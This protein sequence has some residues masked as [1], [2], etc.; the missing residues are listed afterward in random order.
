MGHRRQRSRPRPYPGGVPHPHQA[1]LVGRGHPAIRATHAKTFELT[2]EPAISARATCVLAVGTVLD[3]NLAPLR[4]RV[5][6][7]LATPGLPA[8]TGE[9]TL[10]PRRALTDRAVIRRSRTLDADTLAVDSTLTADDLPEAFAAA[11]TDPGREV[12]LTVE[13]IG[14]GRPLL[15][16]GFGERTHLPSLKDVG[17]Q[18]TLVLTIAPDAPPKEVVATNAVL[19][20]AA[21]AGARVSVA[22]PHKPLEALL[23]AGLPPYP[24]AYW[25]SPQRLSTLPLTATVFHM[26]PA[27][28]ASLL[29]GRDIWIEDTSELDIGTAMTRTTPSAAVEASG[30]LTVVGPAS[31]EAELVDLTAVARAL[32]GADIAPRTLTEALAPFGLTRKRLYAL[33]TEQDQT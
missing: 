14:P 32:V 17:A 30:V 2:A 19:E 13:E 7:T 31:S 16:V 5:R 10:N 4:G 21:A 27:T 11:L 26:P 23:A 29:A 18:D 28:D 24:Y 8:L 9:A 20:R 1:V 12:T 22:S 3:P 6:L 25:G 15:Q 33:L